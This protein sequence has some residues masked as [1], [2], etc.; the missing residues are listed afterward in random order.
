MRL[1]ADLKGRSSRRKAAPSPS[2]HAAVCGRARRGVRYRGRDFRDLRRLVNR[3][4]SLVL[5]WAG[6]QFFELGHDFRVPLVGE[7]SVITALFQQKVN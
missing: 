5:G 6:Q 1:S 3:G 4:N 7:R 2:I